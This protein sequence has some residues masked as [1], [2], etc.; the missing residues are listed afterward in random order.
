MLTFDPD[1]RVTAAD[2]LLHDFFLTEEPLPL[3]PEY[4]VTSQPFGLLT[5]DPTACRL[6]KESGTSW[7]P[8]ELKRKESL[9]WSR[10]QWLQFPHRT[11]LT[12]SSTITIITCVCLLPCLYPLSCWVRC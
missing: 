9:R 6:W 10:K 5:P 3:S 8:N 12:L 7:K 4:V 11:K 2:A 1:Q